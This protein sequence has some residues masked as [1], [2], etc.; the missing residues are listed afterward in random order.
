M[1]KHTTRNRAIMRRGDIN[2]GALSMET[3]NAQQPTGGTAELIKNANRGNNTIGVQEARKWITL[4]E[5]EILTQFALWQFVWQDNSIWWRFF[6]SLYNTLYN[7]ARADQC[8]GRPPWITSACALPTWALL[9]VSYHF[10]QTVKQ[11]VERERAT[12]VPGPNCIP[13]KVDKSCPRLLKLLWKLM[14]NPIH[15]IRQSGGVG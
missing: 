3:N 8:K 15:P 6:I 1:Q 14:E 2:A 7:K 4:R 12:S 9:T 5:E 11:V 13:C 10:P